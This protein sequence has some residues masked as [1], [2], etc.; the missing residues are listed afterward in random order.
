MRLKTHFIEIKFNSNK[1]Y[2]IEAIAI[3][4]GKYAKDLMSL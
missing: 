2:P 4:Y 3:A 1:D